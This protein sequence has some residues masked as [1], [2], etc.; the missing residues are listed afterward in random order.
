MLP[1][2]SNDE[3]ND[4]LIIK[5]SPLGVREI[6]RNRERE[7]VIARRQRRPMGEQVPHS[8]V[9]IGTL[10][11]MSDASRCSVTRIPAAGLPSAVSR[12]WVLMVLIDSPRKVSA[13][14]AE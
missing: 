14:V 2:V 3:V 11:P 13:A 10:D 8:T 4:H 5:S 9:F 7:A 6:F 12:T 1:F